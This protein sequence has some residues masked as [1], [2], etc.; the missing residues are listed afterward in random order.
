MG[1]VPTDDRFWALALGSL[2]ASISSL[3]VASPLTAR[4]EVS[5]EAGFSV[6]RLKVTNLTGVTTNFRARVVIRSGEDSW[7]SPYQTQSLAGNESKEYMFRP[8]PAGKAIDKCD[9]EGDVTADDGGLANPLQ[10]V[11]FGRGVASPPTGAEGDA[12]AAPG[13]TIL[14]LSLGSH[15]LPV[16]EDEAIPLVRS[17]VFLGHQSGRVIFGVAFDLIR[18]SRHTDYEGSSDSRSETQFML[19]PGLRVSLAR[20]QDRKTEVFGQFDFG[21]GMRLYGGD[22]EGDPATNYQLMYQI[23][24]GLRYWVHPQ[25]SFGGVAGLRGEFDH[26][27]D[28]DVS[29]GFGTTSIF[30]SFQ[31]TARF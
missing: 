31:V 26:V 18:A 29:R 21:W 12:P 1:L 17:G 13:G 7:I 20:S 23:G 2:A 24:P 22:T 25:L 27:G 19:L 15:Q 16:D 30:S 10:T 4:C 14:E 9:V 11:G 5:S 28:G 8:F 6:A 3:A